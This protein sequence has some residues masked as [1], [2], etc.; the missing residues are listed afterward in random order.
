MKGR[1]PVFVCV[2]FVLSAMVQTTIRAEAPTSDKVFTAVETRQDG[3]SFSI[4]P[5]GFPSTFVSIDGSM[6][7]LFAGQPASRDE[8]TG[9]PQLPYEVLSL[10]IPPGTSVSATLVDA[11]YETFENQE[12]APVPSYSYNEQNEAVAT[13]SRDPAAYATNRFLPSEVVHVERPFTFRS[14]RVATIRVAPYQYNPARRTIKRLVSGRL[15]VRLIATRPGEVS[16]PTGKRVAD[17][18]FE[19]IYRNLL[20]NYDQ[21]ADWRISPETVSRP[22]IDSSRTWFETGQTYYRVRIAE[23]GWYRITPSDLQ[24]VGASFSQVDSSRLRIY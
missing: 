8:R 21:A 24:S 18:H 19:G 9:W 2:V 7:I 20:E 16:P 3:W 15:E 6:H 1:S 5:P 12:V 17:P 14:Q 4:H 10:G 11:V 22:G 13:Y 23:D